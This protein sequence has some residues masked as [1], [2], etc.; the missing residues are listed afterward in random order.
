MI[1]PALALGLM[2]ACASYTEEQGKAADFMCECMSDTEQDKDILYYIC[3]EEAKAKFD[4][5]VFVDEGYSKA[6][7]EKCPDVAVVTE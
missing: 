4:K 7:A 5:S 1:L 2:T 3:N 6:M